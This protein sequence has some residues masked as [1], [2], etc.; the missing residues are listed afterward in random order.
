MLLPVIV[1]QG[2]AAF[3]PI[4]DRCVCHALVCLLGRGAR[5]N[6]LVQSLSPVNTS[7]SGYFGSVYRKFLQ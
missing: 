5:L 6:D 2:P 1:Y 4:P 7:L 3:Y